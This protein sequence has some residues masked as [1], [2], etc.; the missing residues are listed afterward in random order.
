MRLYY[1]VFLFTLLIGI[2]LSKAQVNKRIYIADKDLIPTE[3]PMDFE[4]LKLDVS[5]EPENGKV[6]G[7][8]QH[9]FKVL[10]WE[11]D[12]VFLHAENINISASKLDGSDVKFRK[13]KGGF[14]FDFGKMLKSESS[15]SLEIEYTAKPK[16]GCILSDGTTLQIA[17]EN[18]YGHRDKE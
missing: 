17:L 7:K 3:H 6:I 8:V 13:V 4:H 16:K 15:H 14:V 9:Q 18:R 11:V 10:T 12:T 5:F 2:E 1:L